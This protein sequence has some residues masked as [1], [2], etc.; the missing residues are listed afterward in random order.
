ME[1]TLMQMLEAR[2][3]RVAR[4]EVLFCRY[5]LPLLS[6]TM[7][8]P[9][10][11]KN[12]A[13]ITQSFYL[14]DRLI[15]QELQRRNIH[16]KTRELVVADTGCEAMYVL[17]M[18]PMEL[19]AMAVELEEG[20]SLGRLLDLDV[21]VPQGQKIQRATP[22]RCLICGN[23]AQVCARSRAHSVEQLQAKTFEILQE[24][25]DKDDARTGAR[26]ACQALLYEVCATPKPGLVD[27]EN[28]GSHQDMDIFTFQASAAALWPYFYD[29]V[30]L[31]RKSR[32]LSPAETFARLRRRGKQ[33]E[34]EMLL[35][36]SG[37]NTH[38]GAIFSLGLL[39]GALGR[40]EQGLW[41]NPD[42]V[43][44]T[45]ADLAQ[46]LTTSDFSGTDTAGERLYRDYGITGVRGQAEA[47]FPAVKKIGLPILK[48]GLARGLS[49]NH[50]GCVALLH[51]LPFV[52]DTNLFHRGG[53]AA[54]EF[55]TGAVE[56]ILQQNP[57]PSAEEIRQ[58]D[59][60]LIERNLSP[61]GCADLLALTYL[62]WLLQQPEIQ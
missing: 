59:Q 37:V 1:V 55:V 47:G 10:P 32:T 25:V 19:K 9:G 4:Q 20:T 15:R 11:V 50:A 39:C 36:T 17:D 33:A 51:M 58:L 35:A 30:R 57:F 38:K 27:R 49:C 46:G 22:R 56:N 14:G 42:A 62:M 2:E 40:L 24:A 31:G 41:K 61:G 8:I 44:T 53:P 7:N 16:C 52:Q 18:E 21:V 48:E 3:A 54:Q 5:G 45:V 60:A 12:N 43:L 23:V 28:S 6:F 29:C 26:L 13:L 34:G